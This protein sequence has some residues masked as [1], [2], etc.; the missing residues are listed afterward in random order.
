[1]KETELGGRHSDLFKAS[2]LALGFIEPQ[3]AKAGATLEGLKDRGA[4]PSNA[5]PV[6]E[7]RL[8]MQLCICGTPLGEG[9]HEREKVLTLIQEQRVADELRDRLTDLYY[10]ARNYRESIASGDEDWRSAYLAVAKERDETSQLLTNLRAKERDLDVRIEELGDVDVAALRKNRA[11]LKTQADRLG[12]EHAALEATIGMLEREEKELLKEQGNLLKSRSKFNLLLSE[13][14]AS[15]DILQVFAQTHGTILSQELSEVSTRMNELFIEMIGA[16]PEQGAII[17]RGEVTPD[18][19][20]VVY[21]PQDR[22]LD[23]DMDLNGASRRALT[24]AFILALARVSQVDAP[25]VVDTPLGMMSG[26][27]KRSVLQTAIT[28]SK[29][30]IM[31]L[32]RAEIADCEDIIDKSAGEIFTLTNTAHFPRMLVHDPKVEERMVMRCACNH[33]QVCG[34]CERIG[35]QEQAQLA[36]R[37]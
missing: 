33:R 19:D 34:V 16:D 29:Q 7:E 32:T 1:V 20:I 12:R 28:H 2:S 21:G 3:L 36:F 13:L 6:L 30:L 37:E 5:I 4:I 35:D 17:R 9:T 11:D 15:A 18:F 26:L 27:V 8:E 31:F 22:H 25:N 24:L 23:P 10:S 14:E